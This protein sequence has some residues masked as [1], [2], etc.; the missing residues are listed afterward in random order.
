MLKKLGQKILV[1]YASAQQEA[2]ANK[3][4]REEKKEEKIKL[5]EKTRERRSSV[6]CPY[7]RKHHTSTDI[8]NE[9]TEVKELN[10]RERTYDSYV[11]VSFINCKKCDNTFGIK[12]QYLSH[13]DAGYLKNAFKITK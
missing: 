13:I 1:A 9:E 5:K 11:Y 10:L 7:C 3:E 12:S 6:D 8:R 2:K 4:K